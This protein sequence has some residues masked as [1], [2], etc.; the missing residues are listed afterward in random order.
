MTDAADRLLQHSQQF[1]VRTYEV[2]EN[3]HVNNGVYLGWA[4]NL[5]AEHAE[6]VGFGRDWSLERGGAWFVRRHEITYHQP[7]VRSDRSLSTTDPK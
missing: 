3:G 4:E 7:A 1:A 5:T 6:L 2:D